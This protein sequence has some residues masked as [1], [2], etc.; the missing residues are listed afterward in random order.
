MGE[1]TSAHSTCRASG[2]GFGQARSEGAAEIVGH[3]RGRC[4]GVGGGG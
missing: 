1:G 2:N 3:I 4:G